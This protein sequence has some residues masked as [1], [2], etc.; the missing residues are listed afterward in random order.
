VKAIVYHRF[1]PP[2]VLELAEI[3]K[4]TPG[5]REVLVKVRA[6]TVTAAD[7]RARSLE[8]P[9]GFGFAARLVFGFSRPR[10]PILGM[11]LSGDVEA[12]GKDVRRFKPGDPVFASTGFRMGCYVEY[13]CLAEDGELAPKPR[14]LSYEEAAAMTFGGV[15]ALRFF[16]SGRIRSGDEVLVNGASGACGT[17]AVQLAKHFGARVTGVCSTANLELVKSIGADR[18]IDYTKEDFT[19]SGDR[20]DIIMDTAGTAPYARSERSLKKGGRLLLV[21]GSLPDMLRTPWVS[22]T[23]DKK[24]IAGAAGEGAEDLRFLANLAESGR[25]RPIIDRRYSFEQ[26]VEAHRYV[27]TGRKRGNVVLTP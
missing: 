6:T 27:D 17:A 23:T 12:V 20:Y 1:G 16:R 15:T 21:L 26:I 5:D 3:P 2:D 19:Q 10:R 7:W 9:P 18:V 8:V 4:P 25:Y 24:I 13:R 11:E 14:S 22:M